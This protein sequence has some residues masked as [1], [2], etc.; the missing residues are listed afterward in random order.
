[1]TIIPPWQSA[2][3]RLVRSI[4]RQLRLSLQLDPEIQEVIE[5]VLYPEGQREV[6]SG[7]SASTVVRNIK[8]EIQEQYEQLRKASNRLLYF[9]SK[10]RSFAGNIELRRELE[11]TYNKALE[12]FSFTNNATIFHQITVQVESALRHRRQLSHTTN[13]MSRKV[14]RYSDPQ[15]LSSLIAFTLFLSGSLIM[16]VLSLL[17]SHC[18]GK[19]PFKFEGS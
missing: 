15:F 11:S 13:L 19:K 6:R 5:N 12:D 8:K 10:P 4:H 9:E 1:M 7:N 16:F 2:H 3:L 17:E 18:I 14:F